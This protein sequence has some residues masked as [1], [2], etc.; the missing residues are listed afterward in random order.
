MSRSVPPPKAAR[1]ATTHTPTA[2][3]RLRAAAI[4]PESAKATVAAAS[5]AICALDSDQTLDSGRLCMV[6][7][8]RK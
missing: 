6:D 2:S 1:P 8:S 5:I 3:S 7:R 4:R